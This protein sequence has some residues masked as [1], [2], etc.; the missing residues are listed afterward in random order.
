M[1]MDD[2]TKSLEGKMSTYLKKTMSTL[3]TLDLGDLVEEVEDEEEGTSTSTQL[4]AAMKVLGAVKKF[5]THLQRKQAYH[6][7]YRNIFRDVHNNPDL[8]A[9]ISVLEYDIDWNDEDAGLR[10]MRRGFFSI[11]EKQPAVRTKTEIAALELLFRGCGFLERFQKSWGRDAALSLI[12][13]M[14][15]R[16][17]E[18]GQVRRCCYCK[19]KSKTVTLTHVYDHHLSRLCTNKDKKAATLSS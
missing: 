1:I 9:V 3:S 7:L 8:I 14:S 17:F 12:R 18:A 10:S 13:H 19:L 15:I 5:R 2:F 11:L 4:G 16:S 6:S